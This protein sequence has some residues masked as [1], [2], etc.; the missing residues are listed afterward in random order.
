[1]AP[2]RLEAGHAEEQDERDVGATLRS[3]PSLDPRDPDPSH[4]S[5]SSRSVLVLFRG[6]PGVGKSTLA[7]AV[8]LELGNAPLVDKDDARDAL[9]EVFSEREDD[10]EEEGEEEEEEREQ[11]RKK[12]RES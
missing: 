2:D 7:R 10:D 5:P 1:M 12:K 8:S 9:A 3:S 6:L 11:G 4:H